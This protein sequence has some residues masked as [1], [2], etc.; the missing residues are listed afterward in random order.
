M[1]AAKTGTVIV[2]TNPVSTADEMEY[3]LVH[4]EARL[5]ITERQY[6]EEIR[7]V[8]GRCPTDSVLEARPLAPLLDDLPSTPPDGAVAPFDEISIQYTSGTTSKPKGVLLTHANYLYGG[9]VM[10]KAMRVLPTDRHLMVLPLFH[11]G[12][13]LHAF[14]PMLLASGSV[15][16]MEHFSATRFVEQA[17]R[18]EVTLAAL[19]AALIRMLLAKPRS[20]ADG[21][22]RLRAISYA[23]NITPQQFEQWHARL[24]CAT[25]GST[26][27]TTRGWT[28]RATSSS[29]TGRRI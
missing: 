23:Q 9:E 27:A 4:S 19:F 12:A 11:A 25:A 29:S 17:V 18:H 14:L 22:T 10:S 3:I 13:Q 21:W 15:G 2:P 20:E 7:A 1:A 24:T 26:A 5:A 8:A 16:L 6:A 28:T